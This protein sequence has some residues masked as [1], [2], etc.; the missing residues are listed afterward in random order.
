M[1]SLPKAVQSWLLVAAGFAVALKAADRVP[2]LI[3]GT[4]HGA[5]VYATLAEAE[6]AIGAHIWVPTYCP[7]SLVWPPTRVDV[8]PG[9]PPSVAV[10]LRGRG[11]ERDRLILEQSIG[12][13]APPPDL[14][15]QPG[16]VLMAVDVQVGRRQATLTRALAQDGQVLHDLS[17]DQGTRHVLLRYTGPVEELLLIAA[18]L[19][20]MRP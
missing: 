12:M 20:R 3:G 19:E 6:A 15:L 4:P 17:W 8:W 11:N 2:A 18:S 16:Q 13:L 1:T 7:D 10:H 5:R 9:P 14:L